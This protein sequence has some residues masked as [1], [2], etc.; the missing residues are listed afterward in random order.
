M[1]VK[2]GS[3]VAQS[4]PTL[5]DPMNCS[6]PCSFIHGILQARVLE[7]VAIAFSLK[8]Y[9][10]SQF[11]SE[12]KLKDLQWPVRRYFLWVLVS[13]VTSSPTTCPILHPTP[14]MQETSSLLLY[15]AQHALP[16][17]FA[18]A[19]PF[20]WNKFL[21]MSTQQTLS[22]LSGLFSM[23]TFSVRS[24]LPSLFKTS[25]IFYPFNSSDTFVKAAITLQYPTLFM[26]VYVCLLLSVSS[27]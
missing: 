11:H 1:K 14:A 6:L 5:S 22:H 7:W 2:S 16:Q 21:S 23:M 3:E 8:P 25:T 13:T 9:K 24:H 20:A 26:Y 17:S 18:Q 15:Q 10:G 19:V 12:Y 4:C 27:H